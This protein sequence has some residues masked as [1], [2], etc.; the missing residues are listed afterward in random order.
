MSTRHT[1]QRPIEPR[2]VDSSAIEG[3]APAAP[4]PDCDVCRDATL[5]DLCFEVLDTTYFRY[6]LCLECFRRFG[7]DWREA[8]RLSDG[9][10]YTNPTAF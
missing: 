10:F 9:K 2:S 7:V 1:N 4:S 8:T 5:P 3:N 6:T